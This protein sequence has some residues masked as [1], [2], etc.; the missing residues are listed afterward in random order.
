[1]TGVTNTEGVF[2]KVVAGPTGSKTTPTI[3]PGFRYEAWQARQSIT[4]S[5]PST[6]PPETGQAAVIV[7]GNESIATAPYNFLSSSSLEDRTMTFSTRTEGDSLNPAFE[8]FSANMDKTAVA[9]AFVWK[10]SSVHNS[11]GNKQPL[12]EIGATAYTGNAQDNNT[13]FP[14]YSSLAATGPQYGWDY[15]NST[16]PP[17]AIVGMPTT[18][19]LQPFIVLSFGNGV[20][21]RITASSATVT[22]SSNP[23]TVNNSFNFPPG[24]YPGQQVTVMFDNYALQAGFTEGNVPVSFEALWYGSIRLNIPLMRTAATLA[25]L[26]AESW[27]NTNDGVAI[28][29]PGGNDGKRNFYE[30]L[31][32]TTVT[33]AS[34]NITKSIAI[35]LIWDGGVQRTWS[36]DSDIV[37]LDNIRGYTQYGWRINGIPQSV[38][39]SR[40]VNP[41]QTT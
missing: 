19:Q 4:G 39:A 24:A 29:Q 8:K 2:R 16:S 14:A 33:D 36:V 10:R 34:L 15:R 20:G 11:L 35:N 30:I 26:A 23:P 1:M 28:G 9:G 37:G 41:P 21:L 6:L 31:N 5:N 38:K 25:G 18:T 40:R 12:Q 22:T 17:T 32:S 13:N 27:Y 7:L 3:R